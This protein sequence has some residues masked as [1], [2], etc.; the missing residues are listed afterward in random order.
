MDTVLARAGAAT[1][2]LA[3]T[4]LPSE[5]CSQG[6]ECNRRAGS[7]GYSIKPI[8]ADSMLCCNTSRDAT[9]RCIRPSMQPHV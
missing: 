2:M 3:G 5:V 7:E 9:A 8:A 1:C 6:S 4:H